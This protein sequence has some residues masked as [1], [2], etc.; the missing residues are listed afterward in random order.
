MGLVFE[1]NPEKAAL[2]LQKHGVTFEQ[3][4]HV[5]YDS[6]AVTYPNHYRDEERFHIVGHYCNV[7]LMVVHTIRYVGDDTVIRII[8]ARRLSKQE[9]KHYED[10]YL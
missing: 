2:N 8:S 5:F 9:R 6:L 10:S 4:S 7:C 3:A 1:W